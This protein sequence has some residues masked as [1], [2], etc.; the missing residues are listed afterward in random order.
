MGFHRLLY[1][2]RWN[3]NSV[4]ESLILIREC[5]ITVFKRDTR[6]L[7]LCLVLG[8]APKLIS[9]FKKYYSFLNKEFRN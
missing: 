3:G 2:L 4:K 1:Q 9:I 8:S 6:A 7:E 5:F